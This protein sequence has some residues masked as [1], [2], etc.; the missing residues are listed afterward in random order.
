MEVLFWEYHLTSSRRLIYPE[1]A[2][3][4]DVCRFPNEKSITSGI[5]VWKCWEYHLNMLFFEPSK[6]I[7]DEKMCIQTEGSWNVGAPKLSS[8]FNR[9]FHEK[10]T[11]QRAT[12]VPHDYGTPP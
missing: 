9:I 6:Q 11:I 12:R 7:Q 8:I 2:E 5:F 1:I 10:V 4:D 3:D